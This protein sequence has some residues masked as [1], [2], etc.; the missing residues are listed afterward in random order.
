[1]KSY[2]MYMFAYIFKELISTDANINAAGTQRENITQLH[3]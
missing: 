3:K 2:L 1:M